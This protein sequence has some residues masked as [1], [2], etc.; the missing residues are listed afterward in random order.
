[1]IGRAFRRKSAL[2]SARIF[3]QI[4]PQELVVGRHVVKA[5]GNSKVPTWPVKALNAIAVIR[6]P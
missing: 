6:D 4:Y 3:L 5:H 2:P 1:M